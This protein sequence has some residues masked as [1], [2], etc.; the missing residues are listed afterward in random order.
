M[1]LEFLR[2]TSHVSQKD[3]P[4]KKSTEKNSFSSW[5]P[6]VFLGATYFKTCK[7]LDECGQ[8]APE[9]AEVVGWQRD[10]HLELISRYFL[11]RFVMHFILYR[12]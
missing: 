5:K 10:Q 7:I 3:V 2:C 4:H 11:M 12:E 9:R 8:A 6:V 1:D